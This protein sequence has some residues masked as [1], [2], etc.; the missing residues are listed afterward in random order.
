MNTRRTTNWLLLGILLAL[1]TGFFRASGGFETSAEAETFRLD[2]C[3]TG[4]A[5]EKPAAYL[6]VVSHD[7]SGG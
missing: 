2:H 3:I 5:N 6:H 7:L 4:K 1:L